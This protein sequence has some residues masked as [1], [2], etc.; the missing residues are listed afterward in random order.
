MEDQ[1]LKRKIY[2]VNLVLLGEA[3]ITPVS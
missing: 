2:D 1:V 3:V